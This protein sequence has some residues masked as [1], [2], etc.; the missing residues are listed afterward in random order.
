MMVERGGGNFDQEHGENRKCYP[1][2]ACTMRTP[3]WLA[4]L[5]LAIE[6]SAP[7]RNSSGNQDQDFVTVLTTPRPPTQKPNGSFKTCGSWL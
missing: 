5:D 7:R 2:H 1:A 3:A 6:H 4:P